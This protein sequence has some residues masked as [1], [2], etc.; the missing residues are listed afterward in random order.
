MRWLQNAHLAEA[1]YWWKRGR[2]DESG[3][4]DEWALSK[5]YMLLRYGRVEI[6]RPV[7]T[8]FYTVEQLEADGICG[9]YAERIWQP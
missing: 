5:T 4:L 9:L 1:L 2:W 7:A 8:H 6:G 3:G